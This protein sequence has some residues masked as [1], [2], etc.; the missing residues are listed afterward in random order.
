MDFWIELFIYFMS[1]WKIFFDQKCDISNVLNGVIVI[2]YIYFG[3]SMGCYQ[4]IRKKDIR[5]LSDYGK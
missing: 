4:V 2:I 5:R 3:S 1:I